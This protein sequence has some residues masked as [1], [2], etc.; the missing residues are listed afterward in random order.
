MLKAILFDMDGVLIN[1][2]KY[3]WESFNV[4]LKESGVHL[5]DKD[6]EKSLGL[7]MRDKLKVWREDY[8]IKEY[9]T[10]EFSRE[11]GKIEIELMEKEFHPNKA[12]NNLLNEAKENQIKLAVATLSLRW[13]AEKIL[14]LLKI[15]DKF[16]V[17]VTGN[18]VENHKPH[19]DV[20]LKATKLL[21]VN[22]EDCIVFEDAP[23]GI[24]AAKRGN[25]KIVAIETEFFP[26][27]EL[28]DFDLIIRDFSEINLERLKCLFEK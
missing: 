15:K 17:I 3:I 6:V 19:P 20:F 14:K 21:N 26:K 23:I 4:M 25:I 2:T 8:G 27:E 24:E 12:L 7:S 1:S 5:S 9:D 10:E 11:A 13:R 22:P 16:E 28:K 18:D